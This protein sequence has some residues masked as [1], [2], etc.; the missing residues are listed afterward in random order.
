[1]YQGFLRARFKKMVKKI[2][3]YYLIAVCSI[4]VGPEGIEPSTK[5]L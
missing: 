4:Q 5:R 2:T 1:M 3:T